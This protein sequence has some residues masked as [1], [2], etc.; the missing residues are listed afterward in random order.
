M[1]RDFKL[2]LLSK[3][4]YGELQTCSINLRMR[5]FRLSTLS[6]L[7]APQKCQ[8]EEQQEM[9][10]SAPARKPN[11]M[12][13]L[14]NS[15]FGEMSVTKRS[16]A[17]PI[18]KVEQPSSKQVLILFYWNN[19]L[20]VTTRKAIRYSVHSLRLSFHTEFY[21]P[22]LKRCV[23]QIVKVRIKFLIRS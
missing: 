12:G 21:F 18:S 7:R 4:S 3:M 10:A 9:V 8:T 11:R 1:N 6:A 22:F 16:C 17:A 5:L 14:F 15:D 19:Q 23:Y 13:L 2:T 20:F